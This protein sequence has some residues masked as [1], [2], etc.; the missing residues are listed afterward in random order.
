MLFP[1]PPFSRLRWIFEERRNALAKLELIEHGTLHFLGAGDTAPLSNIT[2]ERQKELR[3]RLEMLSEALRI[4]KN[5]DLRLALQ[6]AR[7]MGNTAD[8]DDISAELRRRVLHVG[9]AKA[10]P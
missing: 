1:Q 3:R 8:A 9:S 10:L 2:A 4:E 5:G 6:G 7:R